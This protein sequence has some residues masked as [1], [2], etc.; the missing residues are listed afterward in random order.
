MEP[1]II[2][3]MKEQ[4]IELFM[5]T[6]FMRVRSSSKDLLNLEERIAK[7]AESSFYRKER[8]A[9]MVA[10]VI[11]TFSI[12]CGCQLEQV[13]EIGSQYKIVLKFEDFVR[14]SNFIMDLPKDVYEKL[15]T[16]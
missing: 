1:K 8:D 10:A 16:T 7:L 13:Q 15:S 3:D 9:Y 5:P 2:V 14:M 4:T 6:H 12:N 11:L